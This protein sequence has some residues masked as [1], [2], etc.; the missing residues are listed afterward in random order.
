MH[1]ITL[2]VPCRRPYIAPLFLHLFVDHLSIAVT[3][4]PSPSI[5]TLGATS[6]S[7]SRGIGLDVET[8]RGLMARVDNS[9]FSL[10]HLEQCDSRRNCVSIQ[11]H[12]SSSVVSNDVI[13][14]L[15]GMTSRSLPQSFGPN[16]SHGLCRKVISTL[17]SLQH[18]WTDL[19]KTASK[20]S[21]DS[22]SNT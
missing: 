7:S 22:S 13:F 10:S 6:G 17:Y 12:M 2:Y 19:S 11:L 18:V 3:I 4:S 16:A 20:L 8:N 9:A 14:V 21:T 15:G 5:A 1:G